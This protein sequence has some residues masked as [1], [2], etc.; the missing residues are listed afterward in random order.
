MNK[1]AE[2]LLGLILLIGAILIAWYSSMYS[3]VLFG[4]NFNFLSAAWTFLKGGIF[5]FVIM[6]GL[7]L[8]MLGI[9]DLKD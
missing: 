8:I 4:K 2:L 6:I 1:W 7:L 5:W 9:S 3:W